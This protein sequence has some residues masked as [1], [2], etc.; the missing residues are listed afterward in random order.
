MV[1]EHQILVHNRLAK[2]GFET[3]RALHYE[4]DI[5]RSFGEPEGNRLESTTRRIEG[6]GEALVEAL[7]L[8]DEAE[9]REPILGTSGFAEKFSAAGPRDARGRSLRELDLETRLFKYPCSYLVHSEAF[10]GLPQEMHDYV[11]QRLWNVL[12]KREDSQKYAHLSSDDR[13]AI[14]EILRETTLDLPDY[15]R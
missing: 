14:I 10:R 7:L 11:W 5:N 1:L 3:R 15:W 13:Q 6:A 12:S 4:R 9:L 8:V 2:A